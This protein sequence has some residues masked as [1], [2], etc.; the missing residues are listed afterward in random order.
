MLP[1][2]FNMSINNVQQQ[3]RYINSL[4]PDLFN[5]IVNENVLSH[6]RAEAKIKKINHIKL[7]IIQNVI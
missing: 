7:I 5:R 6:L 2:L 1:P 3:F 4:E